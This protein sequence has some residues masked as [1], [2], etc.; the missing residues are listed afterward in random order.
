MRGADAF[1]ERKCRSKG[2]RRV[3]NDFTK[4]ETEDSREKHDYQ[5]WSELDEDGE[6]KNFEKMQKVSHRFSALSNL[7]ILLSAL[8]MIN[9]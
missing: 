5:K 7:Q 3:Q 1:D 9:F 8:H 4:R 2:K 6:R